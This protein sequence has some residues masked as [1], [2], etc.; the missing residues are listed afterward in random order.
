MIRAY[1]LKNLKFPHARPDLWEW[2]QPHI[3]T[4][5]QITRVHD[6]PDCGHHC[7]SALHTP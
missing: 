2:E 4:L 7:R 3:K 6:P 1:R 5:T